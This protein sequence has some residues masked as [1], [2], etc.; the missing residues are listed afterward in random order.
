MARLDRFISGLLADRSALGFALFRIVAGLMAIR[1]LLTYVRDLSGGF[2]GDFFALP[3]TSFIPAPTEPIYILVLVVGILSA[4]ALTVGYRTPIAAVT[5]FLM[6]TYHLSL[7]QIW[8]RHNRYFLV[9]S[10]FL[11]CFAPCGRALSLDSIRLNIAPVG[12]SWTAFLIKV[13]MTL[14]YLASAL[15][16]TLD[17]GWRSGDVLAGR[18]LGPLWEETMPDPIITL[19]PSDAAVRML[20]IQALCSEFFLAFGLWFPRTRRLAIWW[21]IFFHGWIEFQYSV[22]AF[23]YLTLGSYFLFADLRPGAK[24]WSYSSQSPFH[25]FIAGLVPWL[26]WLFQVRIATHAERGHRFVDRDGTVYR[27]LLAWIMLAA[28]LPISFIFCYPLSWLRFLP[29]GRSHDAVETTGVQSPA[30]PAVATAIWMSLYLVFL[31]VVNL[32]EPLRIPA[33]ARRFWDLPWFFGLMCLMTAIYRR[34]L[35][36]GSF[37]QTSTVAHATESPFFS[38][39]PAPSV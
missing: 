15:S 9:L 35:L 14:I 26:D 21:G 7:N 11:L 19:I 16:K 13:Q 30:V 38:P 28:N 4:A 25:R 33:E 29:W 10:L 39:S 1:Q 31:A 6:V 22:L 23:T 3:Y 2:Y 37:A 5:C 32:Y 34:S 18:G 36:S 12:S 24:L 20:T 8:Y 17:P 27:G